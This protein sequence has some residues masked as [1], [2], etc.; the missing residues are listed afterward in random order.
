MKDKNQTAWINY[1]KSTL[2]LTFFA[3]AVTKAQIVR[4]QIVPDRTLLNNTIILP[5]GN[6]VKIEGGTTK[7]KNLFHSFSEFSVPVNT[8]AWFNNATTIENIFTRITGGN[9]SHIE[10]LIKANGTANLFLLNPAGIIF[11][12]N[13]ALNIGGSLFVSTADSF[14]FSDGSQFSAINP[15]EP[16]LLTV[17]IPI[18]LQY[19]EN[20]G[21]IT[22]K[23]N[24][25]NLFGDPET[26]STNRENRPP[27]IAVAPQKMI[28]LLGGEISLE[29]GNVTAESGN[30]EVWAVTDNSQLSIV[31]SNGTFTIKPI[32]TTINYADINLTQSAS[33]DVSADNAGSVRLQGRNIT[34]TGGSAVLSETLGDGKGGLLQVNASE[35]IRVNGTTPSFNYGSGFVTEIVPGATGQGSNIL[36]DTKSLIVAGGAFISS[37][38][39]GVG[40]S[41]SIT[42]NAQ[43]VD[44]IEGAVFGD[45]FISPSG[46]F[47]QAIFSGTGNSGNI[48]LNTDRLSVTGGANISTVTGFGG[49]SGSILVN[50]K[51]ITLQG[52]ASDGFPTALN[53][54]TFAGQGNAGNLKI[55]TGK[56]LITDGAQINTVTRSEGN[57]GNLTINAT[58]S[59]ELKR[60]SD[61]TRGG[62]FA[63]AFEGT[64]DGGNLN[65]T[66]KQLT[67]EDGATI[68]VSNFQSRNLAPPGKGAPGNLNITA[69][70]IN[71]KEGIITAE[72]N[73]GGKGNIDLVSDNII[74]QDRS[75]ITTN[76]RGEATGGNINL[77]TDTLTALDNS[78]I[79]ANAIDNFAGQVN[80][81]A[82][83]IFGTEFRAQPTSESDITASSNLGAEFNGVVQLNTPEINPTSGLNQLPAKT[84]DTTNVVTA[85]CPAS[86]LG[87]T[88]VISGQGGL[89]D[90]PGSSLRATTVWQDL[91]LIATGEFSQDTQVST[92]TGNS[93]G[94]SEKQQ[95][96]RISPIIEAKSWE[97]GKN[98]QII[99]TTASEQV[100][101]TQPII[102][103]LQCPDR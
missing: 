30:V 78:D 90:N 25:H 69:E 19:G 41:G 32:T 52:I 86:Q 48:Y 35:L 89:P 33:I 34:L 4:S 60:A 1:F 2:Y 49:N 88:F 73:S 83:G 77:E 100:I 23:G 98:G 26:F 22:V 14:N 91:R 24:G 92:S 55:N 8:T 66:T 17:T 64:G 12:E 75:L 82:T 87:N 28:A 10:G 27:G 74:L 71:L 95:K 21:K 79:T 7:G 58:E 47:S 61:A 81:T 9:I 38:T 65:V 11:S 57:G 3:I 84:V 37:S 85:Q 70:E 53:T 101:P 40:N 50:A 94:E 68:S 72:A 96:E 39:F 51:E 45:T 93:L 18:G 99:L 80:I 63:S 103:Y 29:G 44:L 42:V 36:V 6:I 13:A 54:T 67:I 20:P 31:D 5:N 102:P 76:A 15:E 46:I 43:S 59:V 16:P 62:L 97:I 56:L